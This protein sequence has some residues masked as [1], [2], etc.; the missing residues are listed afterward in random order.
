MHHQPG[1]WPYSILHFSV[2]PASMRSSHT[3]GGYSESH[4]MEA[5]GICTHCDHCE[6]C[7]LMATG[8]LTRVH[9]VQLLCELRQA[10]SP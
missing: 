4:T 1:S 10:D 7:L 6:N 5:P 3:H 8:C 2:F 9:H